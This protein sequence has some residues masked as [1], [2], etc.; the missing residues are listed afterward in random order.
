MAGEMQIRARMVGGDL[1]DVKV[2]ISHVMETGQRKDTKTKNLIPAFFINHITVTLNGTTVIESQ[3]GTGIS[4]N[5]FMG[6]KVRGAKP[7]D[8]VIVSAI[9]NLGGKYEHNAIVI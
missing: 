6:F 8:F 2:L 7:G 5:P 3:W 1:A 4:K 9:D